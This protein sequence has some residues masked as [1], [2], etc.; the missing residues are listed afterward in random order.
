MEICGF[1][2]YAFKWSL[3]ESLKFFHHALRTYE[4]NNEWS[5]INFDKTNFLIFYLFLFDQSFIQIAFPLLEN[6]YLLY[7]YDCTRARDRYQSKLKI[8]LESLGLLDRAW[9]YRRRG[10]KM[11]H[12]RENRRSFR[13]RFRSHYRNQAH[14][15]GITPT[16]DAGRLLGK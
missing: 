8:E 4:W 6:K 12:D 9:I 11:N 15:L 1:K 3:I 2:R 5:L 13:G 14:P 16:T 10:L 7:R